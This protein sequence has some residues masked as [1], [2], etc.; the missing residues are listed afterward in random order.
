[1]VPNPRT[2]AR[3][4]PIKSLN[5]PRLI[6]VQTD[7]LGM[8]IS[9]QIKPPNNKSNNYSKHQHNAH[10]VKPSKIRSDY[11]WM[12]VL[13]VEDRWK[14]TEEWWRGP[15]R[16]IERMYF[17]LSLRNGQRLTIFQDMVSGS[18]NQQLG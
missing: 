15:V 18:W 2:S 5:T 6:S 11:K 3:T 12:P 4:C 10:V 13:Q 16:E 8:P 1:M 14:I 17:V 9:I 7:E